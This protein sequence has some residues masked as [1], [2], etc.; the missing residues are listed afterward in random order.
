MLGL[1][2]LLLGKGGNGTRPLWVPPGR[3][4]CS[5]SPPSGPPHPRG[6][7]S[8]Q[9]PAG[10]QPCVLRPSCL[11]TA[12]LLMNKG[13]VTR[14]GSVPVCWGAAGVGWG[15]GGLS[16]ALGWR[17]RES[18]WAWDGQRVLWPC[19]YPIGDFVAVLVGWLQRQGAAKWGDHHPRASLSLLD[20]QGCH[21]VLVPCCPARVLELPRAVPTCVGPVPRRVGGSSYAGCSA[22]C[23]FFPGRRLCRAPRGAR[24]P[25]TPSIP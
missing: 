22:A 20:V 4:P 17:C 13:V 3:A 6:D 15:L 14:R 10:A 2:P 18:C 12:G 7:P 9:A 21:P 5:V 23:F 16:S 1:R 25:R 19:G 24:G 11:V 8:V